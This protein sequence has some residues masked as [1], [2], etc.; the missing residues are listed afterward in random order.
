MATLRDASDDDA[1]A[2]ARLWHQGWIDAHA[3]LVP[4]ALEATRTLPEFRARTRTLI[5]LTR[6]AWRDGSVAGFTMVKSDELYQMYV[7][8][9]ARGT[10]IA[11]DLIR[12]AE[13]RIA[14][15]G[16]DAAWLNCAIGNE[17]AARF[18]R[19]CDWKYEA[20]VIDHVDTSAGPFAMDLWRFVKRLA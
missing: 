11:P 8:E 6:V 13:G 15:A 7:G 20:R 4:K 3:G 2:I 12:D 9:A 14:A 10:G 18:Y 1:D 17:R 16:H 5:P 19:K